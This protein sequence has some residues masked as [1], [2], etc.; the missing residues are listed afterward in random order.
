MVEQ[1]LI[2]TENGF[3]WDNE[4]GISFH[5]ELHEFKMAKEFE[6]FM[7]IYPIE[8]LYEFVDKDEVKEIKIDRLG[9][10]IEIVLWKK[11]ELKK[12]KK[13]SSL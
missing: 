9:N 6:H 8:K 3:K 7:A 4:S 10:K 5:P 1:F 13:I 11:T 2:K 12:L